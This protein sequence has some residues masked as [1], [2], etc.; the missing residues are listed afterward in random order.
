MQNF[1]RILL[2]LFFFF[3]FH[4]HCTELSSQC[5][6]QYFKLN[7]P[8]TVFNKELNKE[9]LN[10]TESLNDLNTLITAIQLGAEPCGFPKGLIPITIAENVETDEK[11]RKTLKTIRKDVNEAVKNFNKWDLKWVI[12]AR[13]NIFLVLNNVSKICQN[14]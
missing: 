11:C 5:I 6:Y 3:T 7:V 1:T 12:L 2:I 10:V 8:L 14:L 9:P 13:E 4:S